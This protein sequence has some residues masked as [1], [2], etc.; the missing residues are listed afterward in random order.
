MFNILI[1]IKKDIN[2]MIK[3]FIKKQI[4]KTG[5][6][7][8]LELENKKLKISINIL[9]K[10]NLKVNEA[11][12]D[13]N[14]RIDEKTST[15]I[16][17]DNEIELLTYN[18]GGHPVGHFY[19]P[20]N[21]L[22]FLKSREDKIWKLKLIEGI[23]FNEEK[24]IDLFKSFS[25]YYPELPFKSTKQTNLRYY[26][27]NGNYE[28]GDGTILYSMIRTLNPKKIIEVG[29]GFTSALMMDTNNLFFEN[30][31]ELTF[32]EPYPERLYSL[33]SEKDKINNEVIVKVVQDVNLEKFKELEPNDILFIDSSHIVK[34]GSDV[35]H[36]LFEI[37]PLIKSGV[38]VH[39][40]DI[41]YP[42]EYPKEWILNNRWNWNEDYFLRA[43]LM[44]NNQFKIVLFSTYLYEYHKK[45]FDNMPTIN[46]N[47]GASI[48]LKKI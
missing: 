31:I 45:L 42:F 11:L 36:L 5:L 17:L 44:Y 29:S 10:E 12:K 8:A 27:E 24:Q 13:L 41:F 26:F 34:T 3:N 2:I 25:K 38:Y 21:N 43:F 18:S 33:M 47:I 4:R 22:D 35:Q 40:H 1:V 14:I 48:W 15:N 7:K 28:Y 20:I 9:E 30:N 39:F 19:S 32:I 46:K 16:Q 37:L 6:V 23:E